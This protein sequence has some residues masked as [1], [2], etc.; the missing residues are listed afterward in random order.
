M[1]A[2]RFDRQRVRRAFNAAADSYDGAAV[3]QREVLQRLLQALQ[4]VRH[5]P[6][7]ILD[8][9]CGT[10][11]AWLLLRQRYRKAQI[12]ALDIAENMLQHTRRRGGL[13][14][15]PMCVCGDIEQLPLADASVDMVFS[16]LAL[17][18][19][20]DLPTVLAEFY[21]VL[22]PGGLL[23]FSSFGPDTLQELRHCWREVDEA[24]HVNDFIDMHDIGDALLQAGLAD[25]VMSAE[26]I[27]M[28]YP[29]A[30]LLMQD[31]RDIG[32]NVTASGHRRGLLT[33]GSLKRVYQAYEQ[34]RRG[35]G[36]PATYE[37][38]YG[39]GWKPSH[40]LTPQLQGEVTVQLQ[41]SPTAQKNGR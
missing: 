26:H 33:A 35:D 32:A 28:T 5:Q 2:Q 30:R 24:V 41:R 11:E 36:L 19:V 6:A 4:P 23:V 18:W 38:L 3:L 31:L 27:V 21:R 7:L 40:A 17:Q 25:P 15:R 9:G 12:I 16:N 37:V 14:H 8:A 10:G 20:N 13:L 22:T 34:F 29:Q 39:H 1:K